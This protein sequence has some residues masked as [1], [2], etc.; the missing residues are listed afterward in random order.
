MTR[1]LSIG[2]KSVGDRCPTYVI[3]EIG[4]NHNGELGNA[5]RL[6]DAAAQAGCDAV[7]FQKRTPEICVPADQR[8]V[9]RDTPWGRMTYLDYRHRVEFDAKEYEHI[10]AY[11]RHK[12][13]AWFTSCWDGPSVEFI[14]QF[15]PICYKIASASLTDDE[16]LLRVCATNRPVILSTG[17]STSDEISHA[18]S[19]FPT[20]Q[21]A[22]LH[23]TSS[24]PC[25]P[26]ELNL[27]M[28]P[29]LR[30]RFQCPVGYSGHA[31]WLADHGR[32]GCP[33]CLH[34]RT[35]HYTRSDDVGQ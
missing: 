29:Q 27:K 3:G 18:V 1:L 22:I 11:C 4:I 7:K 34:Y 21:V 16:L 17:M 33:G 15:D 13:I 10:D 20:D 28:I 24:Y 30:E 19:L 25:P 5:L 8:D 32:G 12:G 31:S 2:S 35:A 14:E 6:I 26:S 23:A 9:L